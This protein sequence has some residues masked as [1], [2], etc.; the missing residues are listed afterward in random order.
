MIEG[1]VDQAQ[2][3]DGEEH[4]Q[5]GSEKTACHGGTEF[6]RPLDGNFQ[7]AKTV[8]LEGIE[9]VARGRVLEEST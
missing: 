9:Q 8:V 5:G 7:H 3:H 6:I 4:H 2:P 1:G